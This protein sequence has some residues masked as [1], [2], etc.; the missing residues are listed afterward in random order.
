[1]SDEVMSF[2]SVD[3]YVEHCRQKWEKQHPRPTLPE[4]LREFVSLPKRFMVISNNNQGYVACNPKNASYT[5]I[6]LHNQI[7]NRTVYI[8]LSPQELDDFIEQLLIM[9]CDMAE[10]RE[11]ITNQDAQAFYRWKTQLG[12]RISEWKREFQEQSDS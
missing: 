7:N 11:W 5:E 12:M 6:K 9:Q 8:K 3:E 1:M 10:Y 4:H 2:D